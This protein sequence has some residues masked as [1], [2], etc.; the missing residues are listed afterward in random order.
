MVKYSHDHNSNAI[1]INNNNNNENARVVADI[2]IFEC[3][4]VQIVQWKQNPINNIAECA[5][6]WVYFIPI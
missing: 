6:I 4:N 1:A 2:M 5:S 3:F